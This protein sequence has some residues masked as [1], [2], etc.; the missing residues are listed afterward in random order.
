MESQDRILALCVFAM[1]LLFVG[2]LVLFGNVDETEMGLV[3]TALGFGTLILTQ[4]LLG[5]RTES[6][7]NQVDSKVD[8]VLNGV[9]DAKI[10]TNVHTA[11]SERG[12]G[13]DPV[14]GEDMN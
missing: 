5:K 12:V 3:T 9:M 2:T 1:S 8:K 4:V 14:T 13:N 10:Q 11:M 7:I 6:K